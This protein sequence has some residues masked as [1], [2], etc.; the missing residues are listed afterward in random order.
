MARELREASTGGGS[1]GNFHCS[2]AHPHPRRNGRRR[3]RRPRAARSCSLSRTL[4]RELLCSPAC[5]FLGC[6]PPRPDKLSCGIHSEMFP[7]MNGFVLI[8]FL[9]AFISAASTQT[10]QK[11][12]APG[13]PAAKTQSKRP[14]PSPLP[15]PPRL[16]RPSHGSSSCR[17][18]QSLI[19][20][21]SVEYLSL[22][23]EEMSAPAP[24][25]N[26]QLALEV[27]R[28]ARAPTASNSTRRTWRTAPTETDGKPEL[29]PDGKPKMGEPKPIEIPQGMGRVIPGF[30]YGLE[31]MK[32]GVR[33]RLFIPWQMAYGTRAI[34]DRP[35]HPGIPA[36]SDSSSTWNWSMSPKCRCRIR[37]VAA[38]S[39]CRRSTQTLRRPLLRSSP[40]SLPSNR[41]CPQAPPRLPRRL[42]PTRNRRACST[43]NARANDRAAS[44]ANAAQVVAFASLRP[45]RPATPA[46]PRSIAACTVPA[47]ARKPPRP[48]PFP[49]AVRVPS[50]RSAC[51]GSEPAASSAK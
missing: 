34:P 13:A 28:L 37:H 17:R 27:H 36:K 45:R 5:S 4:R 25:A 51:S 26:P 6:A 8:L 1:D 29:G 12:P 30:D 24:T 20:R 47:D 38:A 2:L 18:A 3:R 48:P 43:L 23:Y 11:T 35:D 33:K 50:L 42:R 41:P 44:T 21:R 22:H 16:P 46:W 15:P 10:T 14:R 19:R 40:L 9:A 31:G 7:P 49:P 39:R 32:I